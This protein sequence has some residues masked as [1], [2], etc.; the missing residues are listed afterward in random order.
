[1]A[2]DWAAEIAAA[3]AAMS[4]SR[5]LIEAGETFAGHQETDRSA[6]GKTDGK[7][8]MHLG[9]TPKPKRQRK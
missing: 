8:R 2:I 3:E 9:R 6:P 1:M 5:A 4:K 7:G